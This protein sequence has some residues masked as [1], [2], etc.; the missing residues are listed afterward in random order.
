MNISILGAGAWGSALAINLS[1]RHQVT[2]WACDAAQIETMR[3]TG[4]NQRYLPEVPLPQ[5]L[6]LTADLNAALAAAELIL[7]AVPIAALRVTLQQIAAAVVSTPIPVIWACKGFEAGT[8]QL[9]HQ[10]AAEILPE[11]FPR[12]VLSGPSFALEVARGLPTALILASAD[13]K[14]ARQMAQSLHHS[15]LRI[16]SSTDVTGVEMGGAVKNVL[17]IAAGIAEGMG[18][19]QN[20]RA[21][22]ITRGLA[23]MTRLGLKMG[24]RAETLSGLSGAGDLILTCT[25]DMSRNRQVGILLAQ[26]QA[27]PDILSHLGHVAEGVYTVR[28]VHHLAQR[29]G[30]DMPICAAVY[31]V[32]Y[33]QVP[34]ASAVEALLN[35]APNSEFK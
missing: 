32:L 6:N 1:A 23:E 12:G 30:V 21:G 16:Y 17:A 24:V 13:G 34:A 5:N 10:V 35:R 18:Y 15:S 20:A 28:E 3:A 33:E 29:L 25:G 8:T 9:P 7:I 26:Q 19:G 11:N 22:L 14:F 27:L 31:S 2:L 4:Y